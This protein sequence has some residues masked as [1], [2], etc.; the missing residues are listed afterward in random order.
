MRA[1]EVAHF[2]FER[3]PEELRAVIEDPFVSD[4]IERFYNSKS[5]NDIFMREQ[6]NGSSMDSVSQ[7]FANW[8]NE[9]LSV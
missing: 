4:R 2:A 3:L 5:L 1:R 7:C 6:V 8:L 9:E